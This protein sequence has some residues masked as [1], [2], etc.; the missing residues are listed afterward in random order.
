LN[1]APVDDLPVRSGLPTVA[2]LELV[3]I[4]SPVP[5]EELEQ[6]F[7]IQVFKMRNCLRR[8]GSERGG[9]GLYGWIYAGRR[10]VG[11]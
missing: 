2:P 7:L 8:R 5:E 4:G 9:R 1:Y 10:K 3:G 6:T 11:S